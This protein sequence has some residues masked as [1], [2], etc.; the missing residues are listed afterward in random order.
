MQIETVEDNHSSFE[1]DPITQDQRQTILIR[2]RDWLFA[3]QSQHDRS[4]QH[5][6][7]AT[8]EKLCRAIQP[9]CCVIRSVDPLSVIQWLQDQHILTIPPPSP[10]SPLNKNYQTDPNCTNT[11]EHNFSNTEDHSNN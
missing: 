3:S 10:D 11:P 5:N 9:F 2:I 4:P 7:P 6:L 8:L 1:R